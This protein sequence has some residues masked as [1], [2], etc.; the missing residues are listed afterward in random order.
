[1]RTLSMVTNPL[2]QEGDKKGGLRKERVLKERRK[3]DRMKKKGRRLKTSPSLLWV[4]SNQVLNYLAFLRLPWLP[5]SSERS[6]STNSR[7]EVVHGTLGDCCPWRRP[8][9]WLH[10]H[11]DVFHLHLLLGV[12]DI[13]RLWFH[14]ARWEDNTLLR[15]DLWV[16]LNLFVLISKSQKS[17]KFSPSVPHPPH[18][19]RVCHHRLHVLP[20]KCWR[21]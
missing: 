6:P 20:T 19:H 2:F 1:M 9:L 4:R 3:N 14:A 16:H 11:R 10:L 21:L 15:F 7:K 12:Q 13:L 17:S 5:L 8:S 18:R